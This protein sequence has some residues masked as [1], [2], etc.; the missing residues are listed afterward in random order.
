MHTCRH[1]LNLIHIFAVTRIPVKVFV[2][3]IYIIIEYSNTHILDKQ[4]N[5][6]Y[7]IQTRQ[8]SSIQQVV[9][10]ERECVCDSFLAS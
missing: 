9:R 3:T 10:L 1:F 4:I 5:N 6:T 2:Y 7:S 8:S